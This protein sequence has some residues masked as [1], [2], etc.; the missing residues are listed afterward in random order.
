MSH[1]HEFDESV[2]SLVRNADKSI[3]D[4]DYKAALISLLIAVAASSTKMFPKGTQSIDQPFDGKG[5]KRDIGDRE[6]FERFLGP[7]IR[8]IIFNDS[9]IQEDGWHEHLYKF[10][11][12]QDD[13]EKVI[14]KECRNPLIHEGRLP[15]S[16]RFIPDLEGSTRGVGL[17]FVGGPGGGV[18]F[19]SGFL[20][21][22]RE[23]VVGSPINGKD[24][25]INHFRI[26]ARSEVSIDELVIKIS[27]ELN[28]DKKRVWDFVRVF[29]KIGPSSLSLSDD[30][31]FVRVNYYIRF[32]F[33]GGFRVR[34]GRVGNEIPFFDDEF[35]L[36]D[37]GLSVAIKVRDGVDFVDIAE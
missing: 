31:I 4:E 14:Y 22:L 10:S 17:K 33:N 35:G 25:G 24:F 29:E 37:I 6:K 15:D 28:V 18:S 20:T 30:N 8:R 34:L 12:G 7:R 27:Q 3:A 13:P 1:F 32:H 36:T 5:K 9:S 21:L 23:A 11:D 26:K 19:S 2:T 16:V